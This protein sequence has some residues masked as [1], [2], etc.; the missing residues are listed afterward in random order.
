[1]PPVSNV[2]PLPM[3][4]NGGVFAAAPRY[5]TMINLPDV[6]LPRV[7]DMNAPMPSFS[8]SFSS[9]TFT[10]TRFFAVALR[11]SFLAS[12]ARNAGLQTFGG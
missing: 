12:D 3:S 5:S 6:A 8:I 10:R 7:T 11:D 4:A 1:M 9:I 2:M